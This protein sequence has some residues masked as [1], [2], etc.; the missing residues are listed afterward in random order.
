[1]KVFQFIFLIALFSLTSCEQILDNYWERKAEENYVSPYK[2]SYIGTYSGSDQGVLQIDI[3]S[4]DYVE[5]TRTSSNNNF[6]ETFQGGMSGSSFNSVQSRSSG[7]TLLGNLIPSAEKTY[8]GTWKMS[9]GNSGTW[10][11]KKK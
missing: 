2:G 5:V 7:F 8:A 6:K 11:L 4:K 10:T 9:E 1:M 3:S